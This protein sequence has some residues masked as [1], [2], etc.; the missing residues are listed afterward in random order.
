MFHLSHF[1]NGPK[2]CRNNFKNHETKVANP[3]ELRSELFRY[4]CCFPCVLLWAAELREDK[5]DWV[6]RFISNYKEIEKFASCLGFNRITISNFDEVAIRIFLWQSICGVSPQDRIT[7]E[8]LS[9]Y[10]GF[11]VGML[12]PHDGVIETS[13]SRFFLTLWNQISNLLNEGG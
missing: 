10:V 3:E 5:P 13:R 7:K 1:E 11:C 8:L 12:E 9:E 2:I 6:D 4:N